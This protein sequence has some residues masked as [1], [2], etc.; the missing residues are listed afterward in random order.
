AA[1]F[2]QNR[3]AALAL[4]DDAPFPNAQTPVFSQDWWKSWF[5]DDQ[6]LAQD[7][8]AWKAPLSLHY[9]ALDSQVR[10]D[11][12][13][14]AAQGVL[15]PNQVRFTLHPGRGHSLGA[16]PLMGP[17]DEDIADAIA[18]EAAAACGGG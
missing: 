13:E 3:A 14:R 2:A 8:A 17:M 12:Q 9:G 15:Q 1:L 10:H 16:D 11:R 18:E 6:P 4:P 5:T 7:F